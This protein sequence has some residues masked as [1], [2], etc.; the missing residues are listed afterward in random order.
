MTIRFDGRVAVV[1]GAG[2]GLGRSHALLLAARGAKVVV[3]DPAPARDGN[4]PTAEAVVDEIRALGGE[5]IAD[6][7]SVMAPEQ[8]A[9]IIDMAVSTWGRVDI[10]VN[11]AGFVRDRSFAKM[12]LEDW[13]A[14]IGVHLNGAAYVTH[15]AWNHMKDAGYGR[16]VFTTSNSGLYGNFGQANYAAAKAGLV[17]LMNTLKEEGFRYGI[18]VNCLAPMAATAMTEAIF[19]G[20]LEQKFS[21]A[22]PSAALAYLA[23]EICDHT[24]IILSAAGGFYG[25]AQVSG[26]TGVFLPEGVMP[27]PDFVAQHINAILSE[28]N[29]RKA[30]TNAADEM[31]YIKSAA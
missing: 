30:F 17:G 20:E 5:A 10:V 15:A 27:T 11:N 1:T 23:S 28:E 31:A 13:D 6:F 9:Q 26:T 2:T 24:G 7:S 19:T 18:R 14:V 4:P 22:V 3:N 29:G 8:A 12:P 21:P 25:S 16:V